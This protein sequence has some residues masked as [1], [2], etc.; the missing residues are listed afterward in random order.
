LAEISNSNPLVSIIVPCYNQ[1]KYLS[2][3][4]DSIFAQT[5]KEW[6]C[7]IIDD[8]STDDTHL[9][10]EGYTKKDSRFKY[11]YQGNSGLSSARN[12][13][14]KSSTGKYILP[15]DADDKISPYY[16]AEG[17]EILESDNS[18]KL[19]YCK[20]RTFGQR[21]GNWEIPPYS[22]KRLL[23]ENLIFCSAIYKRIDFEE[24]GGYDENMKEGFEDWE[25]WISLLSETDK[26][27]CIPKVL[28]YYRLKEKNRSSITTYEWM[29][30]N[31]EKQRN[32]R[33]VIFKKH[34][35]IYEKYF[36]LPDIIFDYYK[37][38]GQ[39]NSINNSMSYRI[40]K[41]ILKPLWFITR[42]F[43]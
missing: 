5:Y 19:V 36:P 24:K 16:L 13:A 8:G 18:V 11:K 35:D 31:E 22:F 43:K 25:F 23:V 17:F 26:V 28:F 2:D 33:A 38:S 21:E 27:V 10:A 34:A 32:I 1:G 41:T 30:S 6:E 7:I 42:L 15:L 14:I 12:N 40:G 39:F 37:A 3:A 20:A 29:R 9:I 4:L